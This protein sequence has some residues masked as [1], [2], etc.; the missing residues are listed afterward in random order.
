MHAL[1]ATLASFGLILALVRLKIPLAAA[2]AAGAVA[3]GLALG[4]SPLAV[5]AGCGRGAVEPMT[6]G[7][8]ILVVLLLAISELMRSSGQIDEIVGLAGAFLRRPAVTMAALPALIGLLPM[9]GG[10]LFSAPMVETAAGDGA[11]GGDRL[12]AINYWFRHIWEYWW[13]L[14]PGVILAMTMTATNLAEFALFQIPLSLAMAGAGLLIFRGAH[15]DLHLSTPAPPA[16]TRRRLIGATASIWIVLVVWAAVTLLLKPVIP[17]LGQG[18]MTAAAETFAPITAALLAS[19]IWTSISNRIRLAEVLAVLRQRSIYSLAGLILS[20][21][22]YQHILKAAGAA[23]RIAA[24]MTAYH[25]PPLLVVVL[26]PAIAGMITGAA[27]GFVGTS[28]PIVLGV[29]VAL[30]GSPAI[31]PYAVLA[32]ACGHLGM[33][34]SPIHLCYVVSNQYFKT[35]FGPVYRRLLPSFVVM[36]FIA[37]AYFLLLRALLG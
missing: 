36:A 17:H 23:P 24:E 8:L 35:L 14:Y 11:D 34:A 9:P 31:R 4:L 5:L 22:I 27:F 16:G 3:A 6:I 37:A 18:V 19:L 28:F 21:M 33:M 12:S 7:V 15:A 20:I 32:Y 30:P 10:A 29:V 25:L 26:L 13:P 2:I 1:L